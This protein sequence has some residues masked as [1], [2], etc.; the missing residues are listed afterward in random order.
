R[1]TLKFTAVIEKSCRH[2]RVGP[3]ERPPLQQSRGVKGLQD[4]TESPLS[5]HIFLFYE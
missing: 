2:V 4:Q 3:R 5:A 1:L